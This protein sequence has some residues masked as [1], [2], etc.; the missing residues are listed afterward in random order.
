MT[1]WNTFRD[2][3]PT[4]PRF[5]GH[6]AIFD[7]LRSMPETLA[8]A[9]DAAKKLGTL[10]DR[11]I[12]ERVRDFATKKVAADLRREVIKIDAA[13]KKLESR[14]RNLTVPAADKTDVGAAL[15][16]QEIRAHVRQM[17]SSKQVRTL[18]FNPD[19]VVVAAISEAPS[20]LTGV[21]DSLRGQME[22][23]FIE[24]HFPAEIAVLREDAEALESVGM[25]L[26]SAT[27][28]VRAAIG[29]SELEFKKWLVTSTPEVSQELLEGRIGE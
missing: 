15:L 4:D 20:M 9:R 26:E 28:E 10:N 23:A 14:R 29:L 5:L 8:S 1:P 12:T 19:P 22:A 16:R 18:T 13:K 3:I 21:S 7:K 2:N 24:A 17:E 27:K 6:R 11:G 25:A